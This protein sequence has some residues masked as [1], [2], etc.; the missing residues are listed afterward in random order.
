MLWQRKAQSRGF[1]EHSS[2]SGEASAG[3]GWAG[4]ACGVHSPA[5]RRPPHHTAQLVGRRVVPSQ[6]I[7]GPGSKPSA[8]AHSKPPMTLVQVPSPQGCP[9]EHSSVSG[10]GEGGRQGLQGASGPRCLSSVLS[11]PHTPPQATQGQVRCP[12]GPNAGQAHAGRW[13]ERTDGLSRRVNE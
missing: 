12:A 9:A 10:E 7:M 4:S 3:A 13:P 5:P 11:A 8:Q 2:T 6:V 1:R